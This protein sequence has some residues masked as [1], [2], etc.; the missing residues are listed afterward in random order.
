MKLFSYLICNILYIYLA[1]QAFFRSS[2]S[3]P[4]PGAR[5]PTVIL[6]GRPIYRKIKL[7]GRMKSAWIP[8]PD[9]LVIRT[10]DSHAAGEPLRLIVDGPPPIP[11]ETLFGEK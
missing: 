5:C 6:I 1:C 10:V 11:G 2:W 3:F 7:G 9:R 8:P 4:S